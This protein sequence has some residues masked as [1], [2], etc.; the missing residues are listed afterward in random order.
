[1]YRSVIT[2]KYSALA[3]IQNTDEQLKMLFFH[4][5]TQEEKYHLRETETK[6]YGIKNMQLMDKKRWNKEDKVKYSIINKKIKKESERNL[7][8]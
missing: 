7:V 6:M 5:V 3:K 2:N 8:R 1:M 4:Y